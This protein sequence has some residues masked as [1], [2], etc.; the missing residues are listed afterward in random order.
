MTRF[1]DGFFHFFMKEHN[2]WKHLLYLIKHFHN[3]S[4]LKELKINVGS[5]KSQMQLYKEQLHKKH[6]SNQ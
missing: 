2:I 4:L 1:E 3:I 6:V 5:A